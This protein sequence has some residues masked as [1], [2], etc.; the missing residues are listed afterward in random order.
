MFISHLLIQ[1]NLLLLFIQKLESQIKLLIRGMLIPMMVML[2]RLTYFM[3]VMLG[4]MV[5]TGRKSYVDNPVSRIAIT[6]S[7]CPGKQVLKSIGS[8]LDLP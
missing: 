4:L 2:L 3:M 5:M 6:D 7:S 8:L 1:W